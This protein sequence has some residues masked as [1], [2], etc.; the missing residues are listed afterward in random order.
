MPSSTTKIAPDAAAPGHAF[1]RGMA[2][3]APFLLVAAP[4]A[5]LFGVVADEAGLRLWQIM[6]FTAVVVAGASQ[7]AAVQMMDAGAPVWAVLATALAVNLRMA[8]YSASLVVHLGAA[9]LWQRALVAYGN[10]DMSY[11]AS[12]A[13]YEAR[14]AMPLRDRVAFF[15]GTVG[16]TLPAWIGFTWVGAVLGGR[17]PD[18]LALDFALPITFLALVA[19][20]LK[21]A[22]HV[23]AAA[24]SVAVALALAGLPSG[25]GL[26]IAGGCAM[27]TGAV[28]EA[29]MAR[30]AR[31]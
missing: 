15:A 14:P 22:A 2:A 4:F 12:V 25:L 21:S 23:A 6:G 10:F 29:R 24:V 16:L 30:M 20:M 7:F 9:P 11:A 13:E 5:M 27:A 19:P 17:V 1:R 26:L 31:R 18:A 28:V 8:M 3:T